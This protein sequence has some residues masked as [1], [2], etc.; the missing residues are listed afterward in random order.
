M[1]ES[2]ESSP[3]SSYKSVYQTRM[4]RK[5]KLQKRSP[6]FLQSNE[7]DEKLRQAALLDF[8]DNMSEE[9]CLDGP[10][11]C[12][13]NKT[14]VIQKDIALE[15]SVSRYEDEIMS[16]A[17]S[18]SYVQAPLANFDDFT[19]SQK[20]TPCH[21]LVSQSARLS[22]SG[23]EFHITDTDLIECCKKVEVMMKEVTDID[24]L[25]SARDDKN[26]KSIVDIIFEDFS[27]TPFNSPIVSPESKLRNMERSPLFILMEKP[28]RYYSRKFKE[29]VKSNLEEKFK[30]AIDDNMSTCSSS[31]S[32]LSIQGDF[33]SI[34]ENE[35]IVLPNTS[36]HLCENLLQISNYFTQSSNNELNLR[37]EILTS[38]RKIDDSCEVPP[39]IVLMI[40]EILALK[41]KNIEYLEKEQDI[42]DGDFLGF[43]ER[44][45][46]KKDEHLLDV[47]NQFDD[48]LIDE[49]ILNLDFKKSYDST[50]ESSDRGYDNI[51]EEETYK[52]NQTLVP[53]NQCKT[54]ISKN[55][56]WDE[57][58]NDIFASISTQEILHQNVKVINN[59]PHMSKFPINKQITQG[60]QRD[61]I[62]GSSKKLVLRESN[63]AS[64][65]QKA[66]GEPLEL[67][68]GKN[69]V[70]VNG[71]FIE[72]EWEEVKSKVNRDEVGKVNNP[73]SSLIS[74]SFQTANGKKISISEESQISV[75]KILKEFQDNLQETNYETELK[76]IK[77]R[78]SIK[79][80]KSKFE[81]TANS[82]VQIA[83]K[84]GFQ[85][86]C[87]KGKETFKHSIRVNGVEGMENK[88]T[89]KMHQDNVGNVINPGSS[90]VSA[91]FQTANGKTKPVLEKEKYK[92][93]KDRMEFKSKKIAKGIAQVDKTTG[94]QT[95]N[96]K[97][98]LIS[99]KGKKRVEGLLNEFHQS[100]GDGDIENNLL[101]IKNKV[102]SK[103]Q[104]MLSEKKT[105]K[106]SLASRKEEE[107]HLKLGRKLS[108]DE[109][110]P[111][112]KVEN[113]EECGEMG[114]DYAN[115]VL[116]EWVLTQDNSKQFACL[117]ADD[118]PL[119]A[120]NDE[121]K[122]TILKSQN[123]WQHLN[124]GHSTLNAPMM[125]RK[126]RL[127]SLSQ[128]KKEQTP[129]NQPEG[130]CTPKTA[131][132]HFLSLC[133]KPSKEINSTPRDHS[134]FQRQE[135]L[136]IP[137]NLRSPNEICETPNR[138][139]LQTE[140]T[141]PELGEFLNNAVETS[142]PCTN[143][144]F[145]LQETEK[146]PDAFFWINRCNSLNNNSPISTATL[147]DS[148]CC[149]LRA[150]SI[151]KLTPKER[152]ERLSMYG[153]APSMN[154]SPVLME[155][156]QK[157]WRP[158]GLRRTLSNSKK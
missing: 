119:L 95:A 37:K 115:I 56:H 53:S 146:D 4:Q 24:A 80:M 22:T 40:E 102:N 70:G 38:K 62:S 112:I 7:N 34:D 82:S 141:T 96:G 153:Q 79:S 120:P 87:E 133:K 23:S 20:F 16:L 72:N 67:G 17:D 49:H 42:C 13:I 88:V 63:V 11:E 121:S 140:T 60:N 81:K 18:R 3:Q 21:E 152:M 69:A 117:Q 104:S 30:A 125:I 89:F 97:N 28:K 109:K 6:C 143:R 94:F 36:Q 65:L 83:N 107:Y 148:T 93:I 58:D 31:L 54:G 15:R 130:P 25:Q 110:K 29:K 158:S 123:T 145:P 114:T 26:N 19:P 103:K 84:P 5:H 76:E 51:E 122:Q 61:N 91:S 12:D 90:L 71:I 33:T 64:G 138:N 111:N 75:Q 41:S 137:N 150:N 142:T 8:Y 32:S 55:Y 46:C 151:S 85:A 101:C 147:S 48:T 47:C 66:S 126:N 99:E 43:P 129:S 113:D 144:K 14:F 157:N 1:D 116:S 100:E 77:A 127:L 139:F 98:V 92:D 108:T 149:N 50:S 59:F 27:T 2:I 154:L 155:K 35:R 52:V 132:K 9:S 118:T 44:L 68:V 86:M 124:I 10:K 134:T 57:D 106:T 105:L 128:K 135:S 73:G 45:Q 156:R 39:N 131:R 136:L 78:M 74:A